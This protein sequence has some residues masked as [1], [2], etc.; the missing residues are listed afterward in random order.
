ME[1]FARFFQFSVFLWCIIALQISGDLILVCQH[2]KSLTSNIFIGLVQCTVLAPIVKKTKNTYSRKFL[3]PRT[4][5]IIICYVFE[6][7][8]RSKDFIIHISGEG[9]CQRNGFLRV[10]FRLLLFLSY[11]CFYARRELFWK[12]ASGFS[13]CL[14]SICVSSFVI[15]HL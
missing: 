12:V 4:M 5:K 9:F 13:Y 7:F 3:I 1:I 14:P 10:R 11:R 2:F 15:M 8:L 6:F